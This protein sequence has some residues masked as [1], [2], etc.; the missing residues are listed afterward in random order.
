MNRDD[1]NFLRSGNNDLIHLT[2]IHAGLSETGFLEAVFKAE[3]NTAAAPIS[4]SI[5]PARVATD[6][7]MLC[8]EFLF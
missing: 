1:R 6:S 4:R 7:T 8:G 3:R 2:F 5:K